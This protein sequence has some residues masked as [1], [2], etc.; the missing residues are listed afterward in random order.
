MGVPCYPVISEL[1]VHSVFKGC[2]DSRLDQL[3]N[4]RTQCTGAAL[5]IEGEQDVA[6]RADNITISGSG[7]RIDLML[8]G[9]AHKRGPPIGL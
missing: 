9:L 2:S 4:L 3:Q 1:G 6:R 8:P 7:F 5:T